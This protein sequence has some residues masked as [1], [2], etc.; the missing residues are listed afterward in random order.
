MLVVVVLGT[1]IFYLNFLAPMSYHTNGILPLVPILFLTII[2]I[3]VFHARVADF[4]FDKNTGS[5][6]KIFSD[7]T[8]CYN[9]NDYNI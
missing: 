2:N 6:L 3:L 1:H 5:I 8:Y 7:K 4:R 9:I